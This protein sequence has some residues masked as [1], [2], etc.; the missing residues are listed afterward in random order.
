MI[1]DTKIWGKERAGEVNGKKLYG[2]TGKAA[3]CGQFF[4]PLL[5]T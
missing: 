5:V 3:S 1:I 2:P 4:N